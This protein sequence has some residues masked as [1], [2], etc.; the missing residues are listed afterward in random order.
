MAN[1]Q[2]VHLCALHIKGSTRSLFFFF[3]LKKFPASLFFFF[4]FFPSVT[5]RRGFISFHH[6]SETLLTVARQNKSASLFK[7][8]KKK[9]LYDCNNIPHRG[10]NP[11]FGLF[12]RRS[13]EWHT[14]QHH[15]LSNSCH[16]CQNVIHRS[17]TH[18]N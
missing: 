1:P 13:L 10:G 11:C 15:L 17:T 9:N 12:N 16:V 14:K 8:K 5:L 18:G 3:H 4:F 7:E 2:W 6:Q